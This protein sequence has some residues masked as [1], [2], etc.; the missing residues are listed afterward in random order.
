MS[1]PLLDAEE[2][3]RGIVRS[4]SGQQKLHGFPR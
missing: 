1:Q 2:A 3:K 4:A